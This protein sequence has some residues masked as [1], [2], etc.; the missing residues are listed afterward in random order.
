MLGRQPAIS[1]R[2]AR[3]KA[4]GEVKNSASTKHCRGTLRANF[5]TC[6]CWETTLEEAR[7]ACL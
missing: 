3:G 1:P 5:P 6:L 7:I 4:R 2:E